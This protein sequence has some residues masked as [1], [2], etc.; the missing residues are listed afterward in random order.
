MTITPAAL[1]RAITALS[2]AFD[3]SEVR[4]AADALD[5]LSDSPSLATLTAPGSV[6]K[7]AAVTNVTQANAVASV[8]APTKAEFDAVVALSNANKVT[9]N[10]LLGALRTANILTA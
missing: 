8:A 3:E 6:S 2:T 7:S 5:A 9:I 4:A 10:A 1:R